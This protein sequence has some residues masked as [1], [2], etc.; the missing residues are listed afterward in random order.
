MV[1]CYHQEETSTMRYCTTVEKLLCSCI[2]EAALIYQQMYS[3]KNSQK[4]LISFP[5]CITHNV[6]EVLLNSEH[7][8]LYFQV[9]CFKVY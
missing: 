9:I 6:T 7:K 1:S 5:V 3:F 8:I 4:W 2:S